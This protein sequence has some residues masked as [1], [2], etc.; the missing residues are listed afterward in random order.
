MNTTALR[1]I[2][3]LGAITGM[4]SMSGP[5]ALALERRGPLRSIVP[6]FAAAEMIADKT[7]VVG[8]RTDPLPLA[9]R[10]VMGAIAGGLV[11]RDYR[12]NIAAGSLVGAGTAVI[13]AYLAYH[14]RR[15]L[16]LSGVLAGVAEDAL[17]VGLGAA[18]AAR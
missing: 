3:A 16:P 4:R 10:A 6:L 14:F 5:A 13:A 1:R 15:R 9:G 7:S 2:V 18:Q 17:V 12:Q 11:A 8:N